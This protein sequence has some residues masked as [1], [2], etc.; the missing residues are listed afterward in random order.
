MAAKIITILKPGKDPTDIGSYCPVSLL[1]T[2]TKLLEKLVHKRLQKDLDPVEW[3]LNHQFGF[4]CAH[5]TVQQ[6]Y[7]ITDIINKALEN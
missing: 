4:Q 1:P 5:S 3:M 2:L 7:L 6:C